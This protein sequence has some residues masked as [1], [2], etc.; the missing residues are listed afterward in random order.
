[1]LTVRRVVPILVVV[2]CLA[3]LVVTCFGAVIFQDQQFGFRDAAHFYYPLYQLVQD[4][5]NAGRVPLWNVAENGGMPLLGTPTAAALYPGKIVYAVFPYDVAARAYVILHVL[6]ATGAMILLMRHW[7]VSWIGAVIAGLGYGFGMP[8]LF[9]YCNVIFLVGAA[10][11]PLGFFGI[12]RIVRL[13]RVRGIAELALVLA[14]QTLGGDP[15]STYVT[16]VFAAL[17]ALLIGRAPDQRTIEP[18][19]H[20]GSVQRHRWVIRL[21]LL[22][23]GL[24]LWIAAVIM[25]GAA[26]PDY[27]PEP[28]QNRPMPI[29]RWTPYVGRAVLIPW[30]LIA[31]WALLRW[32]RTELGRAR[33]GK[34]FMLLASALVAALLAAGQLLPTLEFSQL[35]TRAANEGSHQIYG[36]SVEPYRFLEFVWPNLF[37]NSYGL[38]S[39]WMTSLP[40][41]GSQK[42]WLP[43]LYVG[44]PVFILAILAI[45]CPLKLAARSWLLWITLLS[46]LAALGTYS[47]PLWTARLIPGLEDLIGPPD[48]VDAGPVRLDGELRDGDGSFYWFLS[49]VLPGFDSFRYP[50]KFL[51]FTALGLSGLAGFGWDRLTRGARL[52]ASVITASILVLSIV[53]L[54]VLIVNQQSF[55]EWV[56]QNPLVEIGSSFG[57]LD[58]DL[59]F[60]GTRKA[61]VHGLIVSALLLPGLW[62]AP[63]YL[64]PSGLFVLI[65]LTVD[66]ILANGPFVNT[67]PQAY[68]DNANLPRAL[69]LIEEAEEADPADGPFRI[70]RLPLW[71]PTT[72]RLKGSEDRIADFVQW[73]RDTLQPKYAI[74]FG[75]QYTNTEGTAEL[76]DIMFFF[77]PFRL[78][79][80][81]Q[82]A[83]LLGTPRGSKA[84]IHPRRGFDL[85]NTRY[86]ILPGTVLPPDAWNDERRGYASFL[87]D[88]TP[89]YP[90]S[91]QL[92]RESEDDRVQRTFKEDF[93]ILRNNAAYPR[94]WIVHGLEFV[95]PI[96]GLDRNDRLQTIQQILHPKRNFWNNSKLPVYDPREVAWVEVDD[97]N[98]LLRFQTGGMAEL[99]ESVEVTVHEPNRVVLRAT[100]EKP[101]VVV[102]ADTYYPGWRLQVDGKSA[103]IIRTN[104]MMRGA[105]VEAGTHELVYTYEPDS[106]R[107][108]SIGTGIGLIVTLLILLWPLPRNSPAIAPNQPDGVRSVEAG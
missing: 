93:Q 101:G 34:L 66:L 1:M 11:T 69:E 87:P 16:G 2:G 73:E 78:A 94:A 81:D 55:V 89:I 6:L 46:L 4:E 10:W 88:T 82:N 104:R 45:G 63:R 18:N 71:S 107:I 53:A 9:Q 72:W 79:L 75:Y 32:R 98:S 90:T 27:R 92:Q 59:A 74:P 8:V 38:E 20:T 25:A 103:P 33:I 105:A 54:V 49:V 39:S 17:Y 35:T 64:V 95:E 56:S 50:A 57:P 44:G 26:L 99:G 40:P 3:T 28:T 30:I 68:L 61:I 58:P 31:F 65:L 80:S 22:G 43:S 14:L 67:V 23:V 91:E 37:G 19:Q 36:F 108:G 21:S 52:G 83:E 7:G 41:S 51:T 86:F 102:L 13:G 5:W 85:W 12:D 29:F 97:R 62:F 15:Q 42:I 70:H 106:F 47:S 100:L 60:S 77:A 24:V 84:V 76:Y 96:Q 48:P